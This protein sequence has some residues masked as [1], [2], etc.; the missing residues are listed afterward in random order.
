MLRAVCL[1]TTLLVWALRPVAAE[2]PSDLDANAALKYWQGFAQLP[3]FSDA[4]Q[5]KLMAECLT[6]PLDAEARGLAAKADYAL[7]MLHRGAAL[8]ECDWAVGPEEGIRALLPHASAARVMVPL[9]CLRAR[10]RFEDGRTAEAV[11]DMVDAMTL[12][13]HISRD[14]LLIAVLFGYSLEQRVTET[15]ALSLPKLDAATVSDLRARIDAL[16]AGGSLA[17]AMELEERFTLDW[18][19]REAREANARGGLLPFLNEFCG[20]PG[21]GRAFLE[22]CGGDLVGV[23]RR[24]EQTRPCYRQ[25]ATK[26]DLPAD[27]FEGEFDREAEGQAGNPVFTLLFPDLR[28]VA[29]ASTRARVRRA[30]LKAALA[31][32]LGGPDALKDHP[33]P[34]VGGPFEYVPLEGGFELHSRLKMN[35]KLP[36]KWQSDE[37]F[38][39]PVV[40]IVGPRGR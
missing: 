32:R 23:L 35:E 15:L 24:V 6:M 18:F 19:A 4:D 3:N 20:E 36:A 5:R 37:A 17:T 39:K 16:P 29:W 8:R 2:G 34:I 40:L 12:S 7:L 31:I 22:G 1:A 27:R 9:A 14:G 33:D 10:V 21:K 13:R 28:K 25:M 11:N 38:N 26:L 30:L